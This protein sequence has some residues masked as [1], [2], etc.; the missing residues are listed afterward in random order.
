MKFK[1]ASGIFAIVLSAT[2][3]CKKEPAV[4]S[5]IGKW[6]LTKQQSKLFY[7]GNLIST[8]NNS[9]FTTN[10]FVQY[11]T[12][13]SGYTSQNTTTSPSIMEFTYI[14]SGNV[15]SLYTSS[16]DIKITDTVTSITSANLSIHAES[17]V[18]DPDNSGQFDNEIDDFFY[19]KAN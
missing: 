3:S 9:S 15:L 19:K 1:C 13:G 5:I 7:N 17:L 6:Y 10:D 4:I 12:D 14:L 11:F 2:F 16:N 8:F 18:P